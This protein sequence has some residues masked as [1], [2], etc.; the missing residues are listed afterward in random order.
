MSIHLLWEE[1]AQHSIMA[2][3]K[4]RQGEVTN[5]HSQKGQA[6]LILASTVF[7][8][9]LQTYTIRRR[10]HFDVGTH[11]NAVHIVSV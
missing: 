4:V 8:L 6:M 9:N 11:G 3:T 1:N 7:T 2:N 10:S 5:A